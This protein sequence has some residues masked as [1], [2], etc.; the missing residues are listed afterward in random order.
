MK[1]CS[2][3]KENSLKQKD[4]AQETRDVFVMIIALGLDCRVTF[5]IKNDRKH[6]YFRDWFSNNLYKCW[7]GESLVS[8]AGCRWE[9][10]AR[11]GQ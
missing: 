11:M 3:S 1:Y 8:S 4:K 9:T 5:G 6:F 10:G 2:L 7:T